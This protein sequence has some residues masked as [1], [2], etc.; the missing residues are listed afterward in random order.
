MSDAT[1]IQE[2]PAAV[3]E[4]LIQSGKINFEPLEQKAAAEIEKK[5]YIRGLQEEVR[6][7]DKL[8]AQYSTTL[9]EQ[10]ADVKT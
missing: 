7:K 9:D 10:A 4:D 1:A 2:I 8:L 3:W 6:E 5:D